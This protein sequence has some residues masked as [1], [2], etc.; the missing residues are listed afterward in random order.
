MGLTRIDS[1]LGHG[2]HADARAAA[3][4]GQAAFLPSSQRHGGDGS[5][6]ASTASRPA[7]GAS[8]ASLSSLSGS[9]FSSH[10][11]GTVASAAHTGDDDSYGSEDED[12]AS[13]SEHSGL[14]DGTYDAGGRADAVAAG[15]EDNHE[16]GDFFGQ[17]GLA[18]G[19]RGAER[20]NTSS[21]ATSCFSRRWWFGC[22]RFLLRLLCC[23]LMDGGWAAPQGRLGRRVVPIGGHGEPRAATSASATAAAAEGS[24]RHRRGGAQP[25]RRRGVG[26]SGVDRS[27][28]GRVLLCLQ[29]HHPLRRL[30]VRLTLN[31]WFERVVLGL[32]L[33]S[34]VALALETPSLDPASTTAQTLHVLDYVFTVFF[35]AELVVKVLANG[36]LFSEAAYL[37]SGWGILDGA[38]VAVSIFSLVVDGSASLRS[39]RSLRALRALRPL[40]FITRNPSLRLVVSA[41]LRA[42]APLL[43]VL[44]VCMLIFLVFAIVYTSLLAG[45]TYS[46]QGPVF[47]A[48][49][50][51]QLGLLI[52]PL[53][54]AALSP[55]QQGW[56]SCNKAAAASG[57]D[58]TAACASGYGSGPQ[59]DLAPTSKALCLWF[60]ATWFRVQPQSYD[61]VLDTM[62]TLFQMST[63][64]W[65]VA[66]LYVATD[67]RGVDMHPVREASVAIGALWILFM[68][69][70][71]FAVDLF[72]SVLVDE[73]ERS[74]E[75]LGESWLLTDAQK[76]WVSV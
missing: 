43:Q 70:A 23:C 22:V 46:C 7:D 40:R 74:R 30:C 34:A 69:V 45:Q 32:I 75:S 60:G 9:A 62:G 4:E 71:F 16:R 48:M 21:F 54:Y 59:I 26:G 76:E 25:S 12:Y 20:A 18:G 6:G 14:L 47:A 44:L 19:P 66:N 63:T 50:P 72:T 29:P 36:L 2:L 5:G 42:L 64:E 1:R 41:L 52:S 28:G 35:S 57:T 56:G 61:N 3:A 53:P 65:W 11:R 51:D 39:L 24:R 31:P 27:G 13:D 73:Y 8:L 49:T 17:E 67:V 68:L 37:R 10:G 15:N 33:S 38:I 58:P 55:L